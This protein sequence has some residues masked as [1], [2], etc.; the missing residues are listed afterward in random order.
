M[1]TYNQVG[2]VEEIGVV[3]VVKI[4]DKDAHVI[5]TGLAGQ[6]IRVVLKRKEI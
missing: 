3:D 2:I 4:L 1:N 5:R 6:D